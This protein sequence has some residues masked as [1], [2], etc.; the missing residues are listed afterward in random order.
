MAMIV[1]VGWV[2][3]LAAVIVGSLIGK[4]TT[5]TLLQYQGG[6]LYDRGRPRR[7]V[8]TGR[9]RV[10]AGIQKVIIVDKRPTSVSF[11]NRAVALSDGATAVYGFS[12]SAEVQDVSKALYRARNYNEIPTYVL[13]CCTRFVLNHY[14]SEGLQAS[15]ETITQE[16]V[17]QAKPRLAAAGFELQDFKFHPPL[18]CLANA[19][20]QRAV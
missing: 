14:A 8:G 2:I 16:I 9:H 1:L 15:K 13:L 12:S 10:W 4:P 19:A 6:V 11:E 20:S 7:E 17:N 3:F 5:V 18:P